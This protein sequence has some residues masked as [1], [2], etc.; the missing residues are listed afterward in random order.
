MG[1]LTSA[2]ALVLKALR[3]VE[4]RSEIMAGRVVSSG[5]K[6]AIMSSDFA[7]TEGGGSEIVSLT[8]RPRPRFLTAACQ[9]VQTLRQISNVA[10]SATVMGPSLC[11]KEFCSRG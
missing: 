10:N 4:A 7:E 2:R 6:T 11:P 8:W 1:C 5:R 9:A 3:E